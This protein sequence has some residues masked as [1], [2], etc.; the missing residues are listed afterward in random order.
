MEGEG[1]P[2]GFL[3][4]CYCPVPAEMGQGMTL[5]TELFGLALATSSE[6][7]RE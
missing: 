4:I 7:V 6:S 3:R 2:L 1:D 5:N